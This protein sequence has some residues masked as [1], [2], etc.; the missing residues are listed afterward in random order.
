MRDEI[1]P[2][3]KEAALAKL[4]EQKDDRPIHSW[5]Q[6]IS[7]ATVSGMYAYAESFNLCRFGSLNIE[8]D[9]IGNAITS[10]A[11]LFENLLTPYDNGDF[12][13][14]AKRTDS[15]AMDISGLP[16]NLYSFG[17]KVRLFN[18]DNTER[19][20]IQLIDEGYG[21][22]FIFVDDNSTNKNKT[23]QEVLAEMKTSEDI[24]RARSK[25]R[26]YIASV[27]KRENFK[28][29]LSLSDEAMLVYATI[30]AEGDSYVNDTKGLLPAVVADLSERYFKAV[31]LAGVYAFFDGSDTVEAKHMEQA[32]EI[33]KESSKVLADLRRIKPLHRRLLDAIVNEEGKVTAQHM[34]AY[35]FINSTWTKK[36]YEMIDLA[37]QLAT[38][39]GYEWIEDTKDNVTHYMVIAPVSKPT[40]EDLF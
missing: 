34:L 39:E 14:V 18:G 37:K 35:P 28:K 13:P 12:Q 30:K 10:K 25:E 38:S 11:E 29:V 32:Y 19:D 6:S 40:I 27:I 9:E 1:Y 20:F 22:R 8:I 16:V 7:N 36:I 4:A 5:T 31:K 17:N 33:V 24:R 23:P 3:F 15:N 26:N 2:K 21:R